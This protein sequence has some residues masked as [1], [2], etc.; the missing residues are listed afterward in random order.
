MYVLP[1]G[2][3]THKL[4][5]QNLKMPPPRSRR[6]RKDPKKDTNR[7]RRPAGLIKEETYRRGSSWRQKPLRSQ[8]QP[9]TSSKFLGRPFRCSV[10]QTAQVVSIAHYSPQP[11][12]WKTAPGVAKMGGACFPRTGVG[13]GGQLRGRRAVTCCPPNDL[14]QHLWQLQSPGPI[15]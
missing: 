10:R 13:L 8:N 1:F 11:A 15:S 6:A 14:L 12:S 2:S 7:A 5:R 4:V 9:P 3:K